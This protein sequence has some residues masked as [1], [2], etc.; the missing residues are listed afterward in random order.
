MSKG[1]GHHDVHGTKVSG[2]L[3]GNE[4]NWQ[5]SYDGG[6]KVASLPQEVLE[7]G[8]YHKRAQSGCRISCTVAPVG[9]QQEVIR[10]HEVL[11]N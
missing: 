11:I 5:V 3:R 1:S 4:N 2:R 6:E 10:I 7:K 8:G 9:R